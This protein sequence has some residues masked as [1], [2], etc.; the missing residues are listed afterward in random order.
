MNYIAKI[1]GMIFEVIYLQ[2]N[3][4]KTLVS[5]NFFLIFIVKE[6]KFLTFACFYRGYHLLDETTQDNSIHYQP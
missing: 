5:D 1:F 6:V 2:N 4:Q 3:F